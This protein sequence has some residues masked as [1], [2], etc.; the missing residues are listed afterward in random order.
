M[1]LADYDH[2]TGRHCGS[3]SLRNLANYYGWGLSEPECFGLASGLGFTF[4]E[5]PDPPHKAFV[6]RPIYLERAF[7]RTLEVEHVE[8][9]GQDWT[10]AWQDI[11]GHLDAGR[12]V[13]LFADLYYLDYYDTDTHFSPHSLLAV[14]YDDDGVH[15]ADSEFETVQRLPF[16]RLREA[17]TSSA[18][19]PLRT[20]Y[21]AVT[22][23]TI[24]ADLERAAVDATEAMAEY[25]FAPGDARYDPGAV[26]VHG[27]AGIQRLVSSMAEW[28]ALPEPQWTARFASQNVE[29]RGT[30]G[31]AFRGLQR[32][33][34]RAVDHPWEEAEVT[35]EMAGIADDWSTVGATLKAAS[36]SDGAAFR[37]RLDEAAASIRAL[38]DREAAL[39]RTILD[40]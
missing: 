39:Y 35:E 6:G 40:G 28:P 10:E 16:D 8:R 13:V 34:F 31:G 3:A 36:E 9:E 21:L 4:F 22:E 23:P 27:L 38:A 20:R 30:G 7:F 25:M 26:G 17:M 18:V 32:D 19:V 14:G 2:A 37:E 24:G 15:L 11:A 5:L 33:F 29:R 12:P 1:R